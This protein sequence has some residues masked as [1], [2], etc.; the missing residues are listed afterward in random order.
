MFHHFYDVLGGKPFVRS[1]FGHRLRWLEALDASMP[2]IPYCPQFFSQSQT[3]ATAMETNWITIAR[4]LS[5]LSLDN[6][7]ETGVSLTGSM[8]Q[9]F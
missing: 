1:F 6:Q 8:V 5:L 2:S 7:I 3:A 9:S 4:L